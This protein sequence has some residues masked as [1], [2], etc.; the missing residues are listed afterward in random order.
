MSEPRRPRSESELI[1]FIRSSDVR[2][3]EALHERIQA[4]SRQRSKLPWG[5]RVRADEGDTPGERRASGFPAS[6]RAASGRLAPLLSWKL[7]AAVAAAAIAGALV[8]G[9]TG[10]G[11]S[12]LSVRQ[13]SALTLRPATGA[14]PPHSR[15]DRPTLAVSVNGLAFPYWEDRFGWRAIG[16]RTD[17][18]A[19]REVTTVFYGNH[20]GQTI[21]YAIVS[22]ANPPRISE[23]M[24]AWRGG[25]HYWLTSVNGVPAVTWLRDG[26]LCV[27]SGRGVDSAT[28]LRLASWT[29]HGLAT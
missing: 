18:V 1:E 11:S 14:A 5:R 2:A 7:G 29:D 9:L 22:G 17:R 8:A 20:R 27:V 24:M 10:P 19:G 16:A 12:S 23:G 3:P 25:V 6:S 4:L 26:H 15:S 13:A 28:L 21:G